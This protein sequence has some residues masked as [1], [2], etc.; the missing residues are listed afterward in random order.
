LEQAVALICRRWCIEEWL[1]VLKIGCK[2]LEHQHRD[3]A[4]LLWAIALDAV[5]AW[6]NMLLG[7][8]GRAVPG[9]PAALVFDAGE[10]A[11]LAL[12]AGSKKS[13]WVK[14]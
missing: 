7:L 14:P 10:C 11:V 6:R 3:A 9:L 4:T 2:M 13:R 1:C 8:M 12:L 5:I